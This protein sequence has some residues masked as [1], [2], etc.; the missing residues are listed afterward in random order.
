M[1]ERIKYLFR[2]YLE[3]KCTRLEMEEFF[4][5]IRASEHDE[6]IRLLIKKVYETSQQLP[7]SHTY[8]DEQG[9]LVLTEK[10]WASHI[11]P[12]TRHSRR[13]VVIGIG[14]IF[15][16]MA[17]VSLLWIRRQP[18]PVTGKPAIA[19]LSKTSTERSE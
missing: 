8:V 17:G 1:E 19:S 12:P 2:Q 9:Q 4:S 13:K 5:Y 10:P 16:L 18:Q 7:A 11:S 3:N 6:S 14:I 15:L